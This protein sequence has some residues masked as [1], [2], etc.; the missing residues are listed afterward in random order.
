V[1]P[2]TRLSSMSVFLKKTLA[3][4]FGEPKAFDISIRPPFRWGRYN[5]RTML[6]FDFDGV[7]INSLA[8]VTITVYH[9]TT[10]KRVISPAELPPALVK[11]FQRN[12]FH[13]Q[14]IGDA[15]LLMKW[16]L[17]RYQRRSET[18]LTPQEYEAIIS[19][20]ADSA[21]VRTRRIYE[22]RM[23]FAARQPQQWLALHQPYQP[24]WAEL[25]QRKKYEFVILTNKNR[26]AT[27]RLCRHFGLNI[28]AGSVYSGDQGASKIENMRQIQKR[29]GRPS[30]EFIDDSMKNLVEL[31]RCFNKDYQTLA[32]LFASWGYTGPE[33]GK[34]AQLK[35]Y[36]I[37]K[38]EDLITLLDRNRQPAENF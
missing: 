9:T 26:E 3:K 23:N 25:L 8:E 13:V 37:L 35:G 22:T 11:L 29:F 30:F 19:G 6:I 34:M 20:A 28:D 38:Q 16:C 17:I 7:L 2:E 36:P 27:L 32:L 18:I 15:I 14:P 24:L 4:L 31:D 21:A 12:R 33:D 5:I 10:G 1:S